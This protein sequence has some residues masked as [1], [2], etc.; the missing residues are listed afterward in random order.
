MVYNVHR[1]IEYATSM[2]TLYPGDL[3][4]S[5]TPEGVGP[6]KP[7]DVLTAE[8]ERVGRFDIRIAA[9]YAG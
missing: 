7:G 5:G 6:V 4:F 9:E 3:I 8:I 1:L 2:Y